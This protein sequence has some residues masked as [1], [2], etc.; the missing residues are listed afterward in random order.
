M[1]SPTQRVLDAAALDAMV[2]PVLGASVADAAELSGGGFAAVWRATL[3]DGRRI[4]VKA[5][6]PPGTRL[7]RYERDLIPAEAAYFRMVAEVAPVPRVLHLGD[8]WLATTLLPGRPLAGQPDSAPVREELGRTI[9]R[10]HERCGDHFGYT[11]DRPSGADWP[12]AFTAIVEALIADA[13][14]WDVPL[15]AGI[16]AAVDRHRTVLAAV[17]RPALLH[18]DLW[19]G[20]VLTEG[21]RLTGLVDGERFLYGDPLLD[22]VS[23]ALFRRIEDEPDHPFLR[24]YAGATGLVLD[25]PAR[26]RLALYRVHLYLLMLAEGPSRGVPAGG[27]RHDQLTGLLAAELAT[28]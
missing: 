5:G 27:E 2:A 28:L 15:P 26:I 14:D 20:N 12:T 25:E 18:F 13:A 9:A 24:G 21:G 8:G 16:G 19:D 3:T 17:H 1:R 22:L 7:L 4:V 11:G 6:P 23:P 10:V